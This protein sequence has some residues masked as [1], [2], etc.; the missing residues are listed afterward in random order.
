[1]N[2]ESVEIMTQV[3]EY[4]KLKNEK[5]MEYN[6]E[7]N[8]LKRLSLTEKEA[9]EYF[10]KIVLNTLA[11][12]KSEPHMT[13]RQIKKFINSSYLNYQYIEK[14]TRAKVFDRVIEILDDNNYQF[15]EK[16]SFIQRMFS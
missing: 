7:E 9:L 3:E 8:N 15:E 1:M 10:D 6:S 14:D 5:E 16:K 11:Y 2:K 12:I 13:N 4:L